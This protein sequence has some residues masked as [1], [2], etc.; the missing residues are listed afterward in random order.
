MCV[1]KSSL[2]N[3]DE[4]FSP[5]GYLGYPVNCRW[6]SGIVISRESTGYWLERVV[7]VKLELG[8]PVVAPNLLLT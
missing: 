6:I 7:D 3:K 5:L 4:V 1:V 8:Y 2:L